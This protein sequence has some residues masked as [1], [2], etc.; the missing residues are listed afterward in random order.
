L[1]VRSIIAAATQYELSELRYQGW[2]SRVTFPELAEE[3]GYLA[4][5]KLKW[6]GNTISGPQDIQAAATG[7]TDFG[8]AF[9]SAIERLVAAGA[10]IKAVIG[11]SG[12]D[13][14]TWPGLYALSD[15]PIKW[16]R[17]LLGKKVPL[18]PRLID[19]GVKSLGALG[20]VAKRSLA[21]VLFFLAWEIL[22]RSGLVDRVFL[23][24]VSEVVAACWHLLASGALQQH[25]LASV[26]HAL[27]GLALAILI[28]ASLGLIIGWSRRTAEFLN[29]LLE[30][31]RNTAA[32]ALLPV[33]TLIL[34]I[35]KP[36]KSPWFSTPA[37]GRSCSIR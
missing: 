3:L 20:A 2:A 31:F 14:D 5:V 19:A 7:D 10:P 13:K 16:P 29:P 32:L 4:P 34:G 30:I 37:P 33:F 6:V 1:A 24:P 35:G 8:G 17:D 12:T 22:P 9:N 28:S 15:G 27:S 18:R 25:I 23:P 21:I 11:S 36:R 26:Y